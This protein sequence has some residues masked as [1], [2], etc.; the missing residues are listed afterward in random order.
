MLDQD[1]QENNPTVQQQY[2]IQVAMAKPVVF[3]VSSDQAIL[4]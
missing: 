1:E 3:A 2:E 4:Y